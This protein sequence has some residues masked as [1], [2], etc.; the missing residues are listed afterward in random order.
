[1]N[2]D[3]DREITITIPFGMIEK[4]KKATPILSMFRDEGDVRAVIEIIEA[5]YVGALEFIR[6]EEGEI[7]EYLADGEGDAE[8][9][10]APDDEDKEKKKD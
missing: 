5:I 6:E 3:P 2:I 4:M 7:L 9:F 10:L 8:Y 1:M